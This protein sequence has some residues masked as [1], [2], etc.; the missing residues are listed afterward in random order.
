MA[1]KSQDNRVGPL[2]S[3]GSLPN[4]LWDAEVSLA[5]EAH[6]VPCGGA[7]RASLLKARPDAPTW[8]ASLKTWR[9]SNAWSKTCEKDVKSNLLMNESYWLVNS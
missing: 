9:A 7:R 6:P 4:P 1:G 3:A 5:A 8:K 2:P